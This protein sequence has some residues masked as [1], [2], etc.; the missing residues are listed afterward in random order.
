MSERIRLSAG[1]GHGI[2]PDARSVTGR[3]VFAGG[4]VWNADPAVVYYAWLQWFLGRAQRELRQQARQQLSGR[5]LA[6]YCPLDAPYCHARWLLDW[7]ARGAPE[8]AP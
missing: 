4:F 6:C 1:L 2:P 5:D 7:L 8:P 3:S